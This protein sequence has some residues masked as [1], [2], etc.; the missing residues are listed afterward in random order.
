MTMND[1][2]WLAVLAMVAC[3]A[4][5]D[6]P[7]AEGE[8]CVEC[9]E[10]TSST[11][12]GGCVAWN[13]WDCE[14]G[15]YCERSWSNTCRRFRAA[16][17]SCDERIDLC[18]DDAFCVEGQCR[19]RPVAGERC[20]AALPC[21]APLV[22]NGG[23]A[24]DDPRAGI[25]APP[26]G[27]VGAPCAWY[28]TAGGPVTGGFRALHC[29]EGLVCAPLAGID[30]RAPSADDF[31][32]SGC[33]AIDED[34]R[35]NA[36]GRCLGWPG[37]CQAAGQGVRGAPCAGHAGCAS[38]V[39]V[40]VPPPI[41]GAGWDGLLPFAAAWPGVCA[42]ADD[43]IGDPVCR[44]G[45]GCDLSC[46]AHG[47]CLPG[48]LCADWGKCYPMYQADLGDR[49]GQHD[50]TPT[51]ADERWCR[52]GA[53][54]DVDRVECRVA[55]DTP[56]GADCASDVEC[57]PGL[58]CASTCVS[59]SG[60][61]EPCSAERRCSF[62]FRCDAETLRC[63][64]PGLVGQ[65]GDCARDDDCG[66]GLHCEDERGSCQWYAREGEACSAQFLPCEPGLTCHLVGD[67]AAGTCGR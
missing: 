34:G 37:T 57:A 3:E 52:V 50:R 38:N 7:R 45:A 30:A 63:E 29:R 16:G 46:G 51:R 67:T 28:V 59:P 9:T 13:E 26:E 15:L 19:A 25:C 18:G 20:E 10:S 23:G 66:K 39:C 53:T 11:F 2:G 64:T 47:D 27:D 36:D 35:T 41:L 43:A 62:D 24:P 33:H 6:A 4:K 40:R 54:C 61:G 21:V 60:L 42:G 1:L 49:C 31:D 5:D 65:G 58:V 48:M 22:C 44:T 12:G 8:T 56:A 55:G 17:E 32:A 14:E